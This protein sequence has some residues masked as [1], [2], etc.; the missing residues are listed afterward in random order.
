[1]R[2][3]LRLDVSLVSLPYVFLPS[4]R[5][6]IR[7]EVR[8]VSLSC[9]FFSLS[10]RERLGLDVRLVSLPYVFLTFLTRGTWGRRHSLSVTTRL[11]VATTG[12][13]GL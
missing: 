3:R 5:E 8:L 2:E 12:A 4:L 13:A 7:L 11:F 10:I 9:V 1:M 6:E